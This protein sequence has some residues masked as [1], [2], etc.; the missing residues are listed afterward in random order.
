MTM[1]K[2]KNLEDD[3]ANLLNLLSITFKMDKSD[4]FLLPA[5]P[6]TNS[7]RLPRHARGNTR[8]AM[9]FN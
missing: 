4:F 6:A 9:V 1:K 5:E 7:S 3:L 8:Q 2:E